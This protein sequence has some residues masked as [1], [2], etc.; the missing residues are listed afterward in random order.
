[1]KKTI[2]FRDSYGISSWRHGNTPSRGKP[3]KKKIGT[4]D[5]LAFLL[6]DNINGIIYYL[7]NLRTMTMHL[8]LYLV[9]EYII[10]KNN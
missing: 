10:N 1:M 7:A 9:Y 6:R 2:A 3:H 5:S 4:P 8:L